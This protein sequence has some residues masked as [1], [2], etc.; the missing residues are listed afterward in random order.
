[1]GYRRRVDS[2]EKSSKQEPT[3]NNEPKKL[4]PVIDKPS[5][6]GGDTCC[7]DQAEQCSLVGF[8]QENMMWIVLSV[9]CLFVLIEFF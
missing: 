7:E 6:L 9:L 5:N 3:L 1:M 8:I 4:I 2:R